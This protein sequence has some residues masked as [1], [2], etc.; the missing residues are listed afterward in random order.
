MSEVN[1]YEPGTFCW[2]ELG[3]T[4]AE[5]AKK[6]YA[7]LF[8]WTAN[9]VPAGPGTYSMLQ[10]SGKDIGA[11]YGLGKDQLSQGVPPHWLSYVS[12]SS[13]D[14]TAR[15]AKQLGGKVL[16]E[17]FDVFDV[18]RMAVIQDPTGATF[19]LW[20]PRKHIGAK[21]VNQSG[22]FCWNELTTSDTAAATKF[23][24]ELFGWTSKILPGPTPYTQFMRGAVPAGGMLQMSKESGQ[25][26][27][28]WLV[29]FAV[30]DCDDRVNK[31]KELKGQVRV[32]PTDIPDVGRFAVIQ[33]PQG[34]AFSIIKL[35]GA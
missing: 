22:A 4:D 14:D 24:T 5:A 2:P 8:G 26:P 20:Q 13:A 15:K 29:Y 16:S 6:F 10:L 9:D 3:T 19:A 32:P 33:D 1:Q 34:A 11:L 27:S 31:A 25:M 35:T 21:L 23:Y 28:H 17:P 12:V 18:G 7:G 30:D